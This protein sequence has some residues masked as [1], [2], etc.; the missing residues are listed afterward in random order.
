MTTISI[1]RFLKYL[2]K[3]ALT[4]DFVDYLKLHNNDKCIDATNMLR[5]HV[6]AISFFI[7]LASIA[8]ATDKG[9]WH[10]YQTNQF[11]GS[12]NFGY[13]IGLPLGTRS[14]YSQLLSSYKHHLATNE[15]GW[16]SS[17]WEIPYNYIQTN[18]NGTFSLFLNGAKHDLI[19]VIADGCYHTKIETYLKIKKMTDASNETGSYWTVYDK[20]GTEYRF[21][22]SLDSE[23]MLST[24][25]ASVTPSAWRWSLDRIK[26][27]NGN[28]IFY[29]YNE[30]RGAVYLSKIEY[31]NDRQR[32]VDFALEVRPDPYWTVEQ[33]SE[34]YIAKRLSR[35]NISVSGNLVKSFKLGYD[36]ITPQTPKSLLS[37]IAKYGSDGTAQ[38]PT[39]FSYKPLD[40]GFSNYSSWNPQATPVFRTVNSSNATTAD[41]YDINGDGLPDMI[42][43]STSPWKISL[44]T[45]SGYMA[46]MDWSG[47]PAGPITETDAAGNVTRDLID[48]NGD[49][50]PDVVIATTGGAWDVRLNNGNGF[51]ASILWSV[52]DSYGFIRTVV[53][54]LANP[55]TYI[56]TRDLLDVNGDD[57]VDVVNKATTGWQVAVNRS[58]QAWLLD[59][60]TDDLG[61]TTTV[62]YSSSAEYPNNQ[63]LSNYWVVSSITRENGLPL[64]N[65]QH[66]TATTTFN[67]AQGLYDVSSNEFRGFGQVTETRPDGTK[68]IHTYHQDDAKKGKEAQTVVT[69]AMGNPY[70]SSI[71]SWSESE[72]NGVYGV[73]LGKIEEFTYD[74]KADNPKQ[75]VT[76]YEYDAYGN[77]TMEARH[78]D[79]SVTGD[80]SYTRNDYTYNLDNWIVD[81]VKH[82]SLSFT[83]GGAKARESWFS[84]DGAS[85][86]DAPPVIGN[87]TREEHFLNTGENPVTTYRYDAFGNTTEIT[88][89]EGRVSLVDYD[90]DFHTFPVKLTN[91]KGQVTVRQFNP[92]NGMPV[93]ERDPNGAET[94]FQY[95]VFQRLVKVI[96][97]GDS[98]T[99]PTNEIIYSLDGVA[100]ESVTV[101]GREK[102]ANAPTLDI[103]QTVDGFGRVIQSK[104]EYQDQAYKVAVDTFYDSMGR[105]VR[106][107]LPYLTSPAP[108]YSLPL[109]APTTFTDY[110]PIGR[111]VKVTNPDGTFALRQYHHWG[112]TE[113][114]ENSHSKQKFYDSNGKLVQVTE[115]NDSETYVTHY[116][117]NPLG[118]LLQSIDH[119][120][121]ITNHSY[122]SLGRKVGVADP[123]LGIR[124]TSFDKTG[125]IIDWTDARGRT[126]KYRY[127]A[128]NRVVMVDYPNDQDIFYVYDN[129][130][131]GTLSRV[132]DAVGTVSYGYDSRLRK[133]SEARTIDG[134]S[135]TT[136]W[137]Y[138]PLDRVVSQTY[139]DGQVTSF[140]YNSMGGLE[141][142][143]GILNLISYNAAGQE[144]RRDYTNGITTHFEYYPENQRLKQILTTG[145]QNFNYEYDN[146]GNVKK[147]IN[148][149]Q[150]LSPRTESFIYDQLDRLH[151]A[152][153]LGTDGY[154]KDY[155]YNAIGNMLTE[156]SIQNGSS[157][158]AQYTYGQGGAGPHAVTGKTDTK[159]IIAMF[160]LNAGKAYTT[161][162]QVTLSNV[163]IGNPTEFMA[164]ESENFAGASWELYGANIS[165]TV[166]AD[167]GKKTIYF[168]VRKNGI[169]STFKNAEIE[170]QPDD[171]DNDGI[172]DLYDNDSNNNGI[173]D[174]WENLYFPEGTV[175]WMADPDADGW[176]NLREYQLG[177]N[178][179]KADNPY[180]DSVSENYV[181]KRASFSKTGET[182]Q[183]D[184][185]ILRDS[186]QQVGFNQGGDQR[187]SENFTISDALGR[188]SGYLGLIDTD[189][190]GIPDS[191][192][193]DDD[194]DGLPDWWEIAQGLNPLS[195]ADAQAD[196]D[197]DGLINLQEYLNGTNPKLSDSDS[198]G[199]DDYQEVYVYHTVANDSDLNR[200][201]DSDSDGL[202][203]AI[204]ADPANYNP[205]GTS[206]NYTLKHG[207]F[208]AGTAS[209]ESVSFTINDR[210][211]NGESGVALTINSGV[212]TTPSWV[213]FGTYADNSAPVRLTVMNAGAAEVN[214][215]T[216]T[217]TGSNPYEFSI[218]ADGCSGKNLSAA[219]SCS[220][221]IKFTPSYSGAKSAI[222]GIPTSDNNTPL[223][224]VLLNGVAVG[225]NDGEPPTGSVIINNSQ[226]LTNSSNVALQLISVDPSGVVQMCISNDNVCPGW[227]PY[228]PTKAWVLSA[229]DGAKSIHVWYRDSLGNANYTSLTATIILDTL[230]PTVTSSLKGGLFNE[231]Q[232]INLT[233]SEPATIYY[234]LNGTNPSKGA[235]IY[236]APLLLGNNTILK[237][238]AYDQAG[239]ASVVQTEQYVIDSTIP[240]L[241]V[242]APSAGSWTNIANIAVSGKVTDGSRLSSFTINGAS[243]PIAY[244][245][246]FMQQLILSTGWNQI[247]L[248]AADEAGNKSI[249][250]RLVGLD[251]QPPLVSVGIPAVDEKILG[252][253]YLVQGS[254]DDGTGSGIQRV[255]ISTDGGQNW[256][257]AGGTTSWNVNWQV[258]PPGIYSIKARAFDVAGN[259]G[260]AADRNV[261]VREAYRLDMV[262]NGTGKGTISSPPFGIAC[263]SSCYGYYE[264]GSEINLKVDPYYS[265]FTGWSGACTGTGDC[266]LKLQANTSVTATFTNDLDHVA[267]INYQTPL[268]FPS[269]QAAYT[270]ALTGNTIQVW[271]M[272]LSE[273]CLFNRNLSVFLKGGYDDSYLSSGG[274]TTIHGNITITNGT[275]RVDKLVVK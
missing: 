24:S 138:D 201:S 40:A 33:G 189:G 169:E 41:S 103:I 101:K 107:S 69:D 78:G 54:D 139:P 16:V 213:D 147:I 43:S 230:S 160:S 165:F 56:V 123:D 173:P 181:L 22:S 131:I 171:S 245:G 93:L 133:T 145:V 163:T 172:P 71:N 234:T 28:C 199:L 197:G 211:A 47:S 261:T 192:D 225:M 249:D 129:G 84:Y 76:E 166:G 190:D 262:V 177:T 143:S 273:S 65:P 87:L 246:S 10:A 161:S 255:E 219:G 55:G 99:Y 258:P 195:P 158:V 45:G 130:K 167:Y 13:K 31:N 53:E 17:G 148:V 94:R 218:Q 260:Y 36:P 61:G 46:P 185:F 14:L 88:D 153:D 270:T 259:I 57:V 5:F 97:P 176:N 157:S 67:Y 248:L 4:G 25:N 180:M 58:G 64:D 266:L 198:D 44:N 207:N 34:I 241:T 271:G 135:W 226:N 108:D 26:D 268:Y 111:V 235:L 274:V 244:D 149:S 100:P 114:D 237:F 98:E 156:T 227:E 77:V 20:S 233:A 150:P 253:S 140:S 236:T 251:Q 60:I 21:G 63:L 162:R 210:I 117:Y 96:K 132:S 9:I 95:D 242:N 186:L 204:D 15:A 221:D 184:N 75:V 116:T 231:I 19:F 113:T 188:Q 37:S 144:N 203:D 250:N 122:D 275:V 66:T 70:A 89:P 142:V 174:V 49:S 104:G 106:Q 62:S 206:E 8:H 86:S 208:S 137:A 82:S 119:L 29:S 50:L 154:H 7:F 232:T 92:A 91:A 38:F 220:V 51:A 179:A 194:N 121:N 269:L 32:V 2:I 229:G 243:V 215:G 134:Q 118:E 240:A 141:G 196:L 90:P 178:P 224:S 127:D 247:N 59:K 191:V 152:E 216:L 205:Y 151:I 79:A 105:T 263:N 239:N 80:E 254:A 146:T 223:V 265:Y 27:A 115:F 183:S 136:G 155:I 193:E 102:V 23:N 217:S 168:K 83:S 30:G 109:T 202:P 72:A 74:G 126:T 182:R 124:T 272:E 212:Y 110:D 264:S 39:K 68:V 12:Y 222:V 228:T 11:S 256:V 175:D 81:K 214:L 170:Y 252:T 159:P 112:I 257:V 3:F 52:P 187:Q 238:I 125:N 6:F 42:D 120:G 1:L 35:I 128:L 200:S 18:T 164:S 267:R 85:N 209:R 73:N 48:I